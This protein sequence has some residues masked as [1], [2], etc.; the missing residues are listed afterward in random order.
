MCGLFKAQRVDYVSFGVRSINALSLWQHGD[1]HIRF[2]M[3]RVEVEN[4]QQH[5][6]HF[7][8]RRHVSSEGRR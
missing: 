1:L 2:L 6:K 8:N 7:D 5:R 4:A 3:A